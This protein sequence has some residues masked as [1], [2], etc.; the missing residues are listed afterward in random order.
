ML[1]GRL[2]LEIEGR[3]HILTS[4]DKEM[5][6]KRWSH[7]RL[8]PPS[9]KEGDEKIVFLLSGEDVEK[10]YRLDTM[11]FLNWYG[12]QD[13]VVANGGRTSVLQTM[14]VGTTLSPSLC[15]RT[16]LMAIDV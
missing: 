7:H 2:A 9:P 10:T 1:E 16:R 11:F 4:H 14:C 8:Y 5:R 13:R 6:I 12:Y 3:E 15:G